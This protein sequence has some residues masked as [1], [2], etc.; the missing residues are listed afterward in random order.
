MTTRLGAGMPLSER[1]RAERSSPFSIQCRVA[2]K[3]EGKGADAAG[4]AAG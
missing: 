3:D 1:Q 2:G 4:V